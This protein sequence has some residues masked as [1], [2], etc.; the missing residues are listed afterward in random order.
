[1][2]H[3]EAMT[4]K[5]DAIIKCSNIAKTY[6]SHDKAIHRRNGIPRFMGNFVSAQFLKQSQ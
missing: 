6:H 2:N 3:V 4:G 1:M 5:N